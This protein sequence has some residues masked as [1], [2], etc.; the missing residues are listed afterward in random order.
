[1]VGTKTLRLGLLALLIAA[2]P[3]LTGCSL[4]SLKSDRSSYTPRS[5]PYAEIDRRDFHD[6]GFGIRTDPNYLITVEASER[7]T[8]V[9]FENEATGQF[10]HAFLRR[11][12][13]V[14]LLEKE[15]DYTET[16]PWESAQYS[17]FMDT[18]RRVQPDDGDYAGAR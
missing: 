16:M 5:I 18:W 17:L 12:N 9:W 3:L 1:M 11:G 8:L 15:G 7:D 14:Y 13:T 10:L 6:V 4:I 2:P